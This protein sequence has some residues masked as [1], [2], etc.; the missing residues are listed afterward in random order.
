MATMAVKPK[1][2]WVKCG[3]SDCPCS[4]DDAK[5]HGPYY[6]HY[7]G[8]NPPQS[9]A[10]SVAEVLAGKL[11]ADIHVLAKKKQT[12]AKSS[13]DYGGWYNEAHMEICW[14]EMVHLIR[15]WESNLTKLDGKGS[16]VDVL[17]QLGNAL[18]TA[19]K[20]AYPE[21]AIFEQ[22]YEAV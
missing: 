16:A 21:E 22:T 3:K 6:H 11:L 7:F 5:K 20:I 13:M 14:L 1:A 15:E 4:T 8:K 12:Q 18:E 17:H 9:N 19:E 2:F 10:G